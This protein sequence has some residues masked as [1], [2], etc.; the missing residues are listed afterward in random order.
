MI[1]SL[2][3][4]L[5]ALPGLRPSAPAAAAVTEE[6]RSP[7]GGT[8]WRFETYPLPFETR[9]V[10]VHQFHRS[11]SGYDLAPPSGTIAIEVE[12]EEARRWAHQLGRTWVVRS[13]GRERV[14]RLN[15]PIATFRAPG[16]LTGLP[17]LQTWRWEAISTRR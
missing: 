2:T 10:A 12:S 8:Y 16:S 1:G 14:L 4:A 9:D 17:E 7:G 5:T 11:G 6:R 15:G 3:R 13:D